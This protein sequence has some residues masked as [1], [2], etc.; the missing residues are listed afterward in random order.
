M[1]RRAF[2]REYKLEAVKQV[3]ERGVASAVVARELGIGANVL[4]RWVR[5]ASGDIRKAFPGEGQQSADQAEIERLKREIIKLKAEKDILK[6]SRGLLRERVELRFSFMAKHRGIWPMR[7]M[8]EALDVSR[9]G[10]YAWLKRPPCQRRRFDEQLTISIK[11]SFEDS[12]RTYGARRVRRDLR[13]WGLLCGIHRVER[14][15]LASGLQARR[16]R[17][18]LPFDTGLRSINAIAPNLLDREFEASGPNRRWVADFTYIWTDEGW[19]YVAAVLDLYS[20]LVVGWS[21]QEQMTARL[22]SDA[23]LMAI[24]R[25]RPAADLLHHSDQ[26]S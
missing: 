26:G 19:L 13:A 22:V 8:C 1:K 4:N 9:G 14:L 18:R 15:M 25:R 3:R 23:M 16:K 24:W 17:R 21:M 10:Y 20:R 11:R 5:E 12:D 6:K 7:W 2:S